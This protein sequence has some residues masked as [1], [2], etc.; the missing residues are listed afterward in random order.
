MEKLILQRKL[1]NQCAICM[2]STPL[3]D[4]VCAVVEHTPLENV[5]IE[6]CPH[7]YIHPNQKDKFLNQNY[8]YGKEI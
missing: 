2:S 6:I 1:K 8:N 3:G 5:I 4:V 7:H